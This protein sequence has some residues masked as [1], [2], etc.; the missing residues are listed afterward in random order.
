MPD[1]DIDQFTREAA[2]LTH[3]APVYFAPSPEARPPEIR[4][5]GTVALVDTGE[6]KLLVTCSHVWDE[7]EEYMQGFPA[8][9]LCTVFASGWGHPIR[10]RKGPVQIDRDIDLAVSDAWPRLWR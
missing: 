9:C 2:L 10:L 7:F 4:A 1:I 5:N 8:A 3:C 6:R